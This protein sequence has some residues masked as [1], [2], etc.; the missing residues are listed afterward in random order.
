MVYPKTNRNHRTTVKPVLEVS[1]G[2]CFGKIPL[3]ARR[4]AAWGLEVT[5][6]AISTIAPF[7]LGLIANTRSVEETVPLNPILMSTQDAIARTFFLPKR[8]LHKTVTPLTN[9]L[10]SAALAAPILLT[11]YQLYGLAKTGENW[12]KRLLGLQVVTLE[13]TPPG[14]DRA[15]RR[16][17][18]GR[19]GIPLGGA[20]LVWCWSG[21]FPR[22]GILSTL[23]ILGLL[24]EGLT[25]QLHRR[26]RAFHDYL[27]A[28]Y[29]IE[30]QT[31]YSHGQ[32][33]TPTDG[34]S[35]FRSGSSLLGKGASDDD[36]YSLTWTEAAGGLTSVVLTPQSMGRPRKL[37]SWRS[38][39]FGRR[40]GFTLGV[41]S[42]MGLVGLAGG[43]GVMPRYRQQQTQWQD[44]AGRNDRVFLALVEMLTSNANPQA[45]EHR[46]AILALASSEDP[47]AISLVVDLLAQTNHR[48]VMEATQQ[49]LVTIG[50][51]ALPFLKRLNQT[52]RNDQ[53]ALQS[54]ESTQYT[55]I[56]LRQQTVKRAIAKILTLY[57]DQLHD[58]DL[59]RTDLGQVKK[60]VSQFRLVLDQTNLA[61]VQLRGAILSGASFRKGRFFGPGEDA[62]PGTY[63]DW[64]TDLSGADLKEADFTDADLNQAIMQRSS[65]LRAILHRVDLSQANLMGTNLSSARLIGANLQRA[66]L[67]DALL[68]GADLTDAN[69]SHAVLQGARLRRASAV[70]AV[71]QVANL[72][73]S[74]W[75]NAD[76]TDVD[77]SGAN[78]QSANLGGA[79]LKR[80]NLSHANLQA[81]RLRGANL[82]EITL[83][84]ANLIETDFQDAIF[85]TSRVADRDQ[86]IRAILDDNITHQFEGVDFSQAYNL[87][88]E[89]LTYICAQGG[90]HPACR[91]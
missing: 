39:R 69:L 45:M 32:G 11:G 83:Q 2:S 79:Y 41:V 4:L 91:P 13:G 89:Q 25:A 71:L 88:N 78:L 48:E 56:A 34:Y 22:L 20:Y 9:L 1:Y 73:Q 82:T 87:D 80:A 86:F 7:Y 59:S 50:P 27:A 77:L 75:Q 66:I 35:P 53:A 36:A 44:M 47:R 81:A 63:D 6:L 18:L 33:M 67:N 23:A 37:N 17:L 19:W 51:E 3:G 57:S 38:R 21:A 60:G 40:F 58:A 28:T 29:V 52:L 62:R 14:L 5:L 30:S 8:T 72:A 74:N 65:L 54:E 64:I 46:T 84:H 61:G 85:F 55:T 70:G 42:L 90:I 76:L 43:L 12:P 16:E 31:I 15:I 68:T 24:A 26:R 49:A 10:W